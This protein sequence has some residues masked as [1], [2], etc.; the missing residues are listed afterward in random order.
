MPKITMLGTGT[1]D[2]VPMIGCD[3][4]VCRSPDPKDKR[5][6]TSAL[7][8]INGKSIVI[9]TGTDFRYQA[10]KYGIK[11]LD[12]ILYTH[13]HADHVEGITELRPLTLAQGRKLPCRGSRRCIDEIHTRFYYMFNGKQ[14]GGGIPTLDMQIIT[15]PFEIQGIKIIPLPVYHGQ[16]L[17]YGFRIG[18]LAYITD[19]SYIPDTT[20][21]LLQGIEVL[22]INGL[23][24]K[25]H[26][27][28]FSYQQAV[29]AGRLSG[30]GQCWLIHMAHHL[31]HQELTALLPENFHPAY[32]GLTV[33][34]A[35]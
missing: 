28:H 7:L 27:T 12:A 33:S 24:P 16:L 18:N 9:D 31:S 15:E 23:R 29:E 10:L 22:F 4:A 19:A 2:G 14:S 8:E 6:R 34:F 17:I 3:C 26:P 1:S 30:A 32:D 5:L 11:R 25:P 13:S 21:K 20:Y 35:L